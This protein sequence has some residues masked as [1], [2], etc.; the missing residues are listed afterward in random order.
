M[1]DIENTNIHGQK[2]RG[3]CQKKKDIRMRERNCEDDKDS[4]KIKG[5]GQIPPKK[6]PSQV[7]Y[8]QQGTPRF[9]ILN[10]ISI[11]VSTIVYN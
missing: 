10:H 2:K 7:K 3:N 1:K 11:V 5:Q 9:L 4:Q 8:F 6:R